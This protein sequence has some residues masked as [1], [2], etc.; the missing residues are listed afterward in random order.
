MRIV[1]DS[2]SEGQLKGVYKIDCSYGKS[3]IGETG[4]SL[5]KRLKE[6]GADIKHERSRTS[7]LANHS[8]KTKHHLRPEDAR[9]IAREEHYQRRKIR[10][11]PEIIKHPHN[12]NRDGG[13]EISDSWRPLIRQIC[14]LGSSSSNV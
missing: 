2:T 11:A 4:H 8:S 3:Y 14:S 13:F 9:I 7:A 6:H 1:K 10:E 12:I 5:Q